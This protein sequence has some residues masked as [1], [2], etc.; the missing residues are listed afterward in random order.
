MS[1]PVVAV[2]AEVV[3]EAAAEGGAP[4]CVR[5]KRLLPD[6]LERVQQALVHLLKGPD[7]LSR[8]TVELHKYPGDMWS[9]HPPA[10]SPQMRSAGY[11]L[12]V[13]CAQLVAGWSYHKR[14]VAN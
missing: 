7:R 14:M 6:R 10:Q 1:L 4:A 11:G 9:E 2:A 12:H 8:K 13:N 3:H 5:A